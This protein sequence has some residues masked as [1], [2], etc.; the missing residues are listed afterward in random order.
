MA[1]A[2][3]SQK[4]S[5]A[6]NKTIDILQSEIGL[7]REDRITLQ[8]YLLE[9]QP[10]R[11]GQNSTVQSSDNSQL[12]QSQ[13]ASFELKLSKFKQKV[14]S[15][16]DDSRRETQSALQQMTQRIDDYRNIALND[17]K[18]LEA[19]IWNDGRLYLLKG[20]IENHATQTI[21]RQLDKNEG[22]GSVANDYLRLAINQLQSTV[23]R[24]EQ[25]LNSGHD[26]PAFQPQ[27][28]PPSLNNLPRNDQIV[29]DALQE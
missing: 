18:T 27:V 15:R 14:N 7:I 19:N 24:H 21:Q 23:Q 20:E 12:L 9:F 11:N 5:Q 22:G 6:N 16:V 26:I 28:D 25:I 2:I 17:M 4:N 1:N 3:E 8:K 10:G 13:Q 29:M